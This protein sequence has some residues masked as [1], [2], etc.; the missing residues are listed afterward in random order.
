MKIN[1]RQEKDVTVVELTGDMNIGTG[2]VAFRRTVRQL[3]DQ[4]SR[5]LL[6]DMAG[7]R[8]M[9][10][11]GLGELVRSKTTAAAAGA[12]IRLLHVEDKVH[13]SLKMAQ[14]IGVFETFDDE[15][16]ALRSFA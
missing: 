14:L 2:D 16:D 9:D 12:T 10:S 6:I 4:G 8:S 1:T 7:V 13:R 11:S 5:K 15:I 3:L